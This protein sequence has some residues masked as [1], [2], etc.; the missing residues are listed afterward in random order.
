MSAGLTWLIRPS[1]LMTLIKNLGRH[2]T[3]LEEI[4][5]PVP[6]M[7]GF[8]AASAQCRS[9]HRPS[10]PL[11][12]ALP[13]VANGHSEWQHA[14]ESQPSSSRPGDTGFGDI[15]PQMTT[16]R[17]MLMGERDPQAPL[18]VPMVGGIVVHAPPTAGRGREAG[19]G[20][21]G[22]RWG[23]HV[24]PTGIKPGRLSSRRL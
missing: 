1:A 14:Q 23:W 5:L 10:S 22:D 7:E 6:A 4:V 21:G 12:V 20:W 8:A 15:N 17:L 3:M 2:I 11:V 13:S 9:G 19:E 24:G 16:P 18:L